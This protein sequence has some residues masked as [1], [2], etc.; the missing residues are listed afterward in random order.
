MKDTMQIHGEVYV[1]EYK[2]STIYS[3][4]GI[5]QCFFLINVEF[6]FVW[7]LGFFSLLPLYAQIVCRLALCLVFEKR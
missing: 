1:Y 7:F 5:F 6:W 4:F 3:V 2:F